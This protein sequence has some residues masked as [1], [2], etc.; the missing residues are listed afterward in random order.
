M[1]STKLISVAFAV[2]AAVLCCYRIS[3]TYFIFDDFLNFQMYLERG[4]SLE[5]YFYYPV[6]GQTVPGYRLMQALVFEAFGPNNHATIVLISLMSGV[7]TGLAVAACA[8]LNDDRW[9]LLILG[10]FLAFSYQQLDAQLWWASSLHSF[11]GLIAAL[12]MILLL[13]ARFPHADKYAALALLVGLQFYS[14]TLFAM[15]IAFGLLMAD[16][17]IEAFWPR[18]RSAVWRVKYTVLIAVLY[19][20]LIKAVGAPVGDTHA[21][22]ASV[23]LF[24][25]QAFSDATLAALIGL[26]AHGATWLGKWTPAPGILLFG[27][28]A[29]CSIYLNGRRAVFA[30]LG[31][32]GYF[33]VSMTVVGT[34]RS[35][36]FAES[37]LWPRYSL[38]NIV[39]LMLT[40]AAAF[41]GHPIPAGTWRVVTVGAACVAAVVLQ[42]Q[43]R[44]IYHHVD[45]VPIRAFIENLRK[46]VAQLP[47]GSLV[48]EGVLPEFIMGSWIAPYNQ[49]SLFLP[50]YSRLAVVPRERATV[51]IGADGV[52]RPIR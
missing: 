48:A 6:F 14:K 49:V 17:S 8:R 41:R 24:L 5:R 9:L 4:W 20:I 2:V 29:G 28:I 47:A 13:L 38:E 11:P 45:Y 42:I 40:I 21:T 51:E 16:S 46:S 27:L 26:G 52:V 44:T 15:I 43:S 35:G 31:Y 36:H 1:S 10:V 3:H 32:A 37:G 23:L 25:W 50:V 22:V 33:V 34:V 19:A 30:W 39:F 12:V 18:V 7:A